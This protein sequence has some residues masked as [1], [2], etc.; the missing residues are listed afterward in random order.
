MSDVC[1]RLQ[2]LTSGS[3]RNVTKDGTSVNVTKDENVTKDVVFTRMPDESYR[4][5]FGALLLCSC[6]VFRTLLNCLCLLSIPV[7]KNL[8]QRKNQVLKERKKKLS[9]KLQV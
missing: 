8:G 7:G 4:K 1:N 9:L 5:L 3:S 2:G 6:N